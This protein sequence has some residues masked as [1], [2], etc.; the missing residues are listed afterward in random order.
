MKK[1]IFQASLAIAMP[2]LLI[3]CGPTQ[4]TATTDTTEPDVAQ[5]EVTE[6]AETADTGDLQAYANGEE[7]PQV[8]FTSAD[9]W[10]LTFDHIYVHLSD[11]SAYQMDPP[12]DYTSQEAIQD[13]EVEVSWEPTT[14]DLVTGDEDDPTVRVG[15]VSNAQPGHYNAISWRMAPA[16]DG[17]AEGYSMVII[18]TGERDGETVD[19]VLNIDREFAYSCGDFVGDERKGFLEAG[20]TADVEA[21]FHFDHLFGEGSRSPDDALNVSAFGFE[22]LAALATDGRIEADLDTLQ[23]ALPVEDFARL[24]SSL[25]E[26]GHAGEGHCYEAISGQTS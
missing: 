12:Y 18:G 19:F 22:P 8:G 15:E 1:Q 17:P 26:L 4:D 21:T 5:T 9:G 25:V 10:D 2:A 7:R 16:P 6:T 23:A 13:A 11:I 20:E 3:G 24:E 14:V